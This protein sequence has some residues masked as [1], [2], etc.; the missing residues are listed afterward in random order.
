M[1]RDELL[2]YYERELRFIRKLAGE[3]A[4]KYP[5]VAS[6]L[7]LE[8]TKCE[9]PHVERI[10]EA[11]AM[12][13]GRIH[14]RLDD[15]FSEI[16]DAMMGIL[17]PHYLRPVPSMTIVQMTA[18]PDV[19][20]VSGGFKIEAGSMLHSAPAGGVRCQFRTSYPLSLY[21]IRVSEVEVM[22]T[23]SLR[24]APIPADARSMLRIRLETQAGV[25]FSALDMDAL[26]F[27]LDATSGEIDALYELFL[28][29]PKGLYVQPVATGEA[30]SP[31]PSG[32]F[33]R[34]EKIQPV[35]FGTDEGL[36]AYPSESFLGYRLLQEYFTFPDKF[37]F[38]ELGGLADV[39]RSADTTILDIMVLLP[40]TQGQIELRVEPANLKLG[41]TP[42]VNLFPR[43]TDPIR[44]TQNT[45]EYPI[46][47]DVRALDA[48]EVHSI[49]KVTSITPG[50]GQTTEY[51]P[52]YGVR[53][54][55]NGRETA[56]WHAQRRP[57]M[58]KGDSGS[59]VF[60]S[61]VD[62]QFKLLSAPVDVLH[63]DALCTNRAL[64]ARLPFGNAA[65]DF[66][67]EGRP[68]IT[69]IVALRKPTDPLPA[70]AASSNRWRLISHLSLNYI[71]LLD[72]GQSMGHEGD[73]KALNALQEI[74]RLYDFADSPV[75]RQKV[76]GVVGLKSRRIVRRVGSGPASGFARGLEAELEFDASQYT[77]SGVF[78]FASV[79]ERF[80]GLYTSVNSFTQTVAK[81]RQHPGVLKRW[82][83]RAGEMTLL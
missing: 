33:V 43:G 23:T 4:E 51:E 71:S 19:S 68:G 66:R 60:I 75:T 16:T 67:L 83:P 49:Q 24:G 74:L 11:F 53:H 20:A 1:R 35:G 50:T 17:Y 29:D 79:L 80:L 22:S 15:E 5:Q 55:S 77:G 65:G 10:I 64:P 59:E 38:V 40:Q 37:L 39:T 18:D 57:S 2:V 28:R 42:A 41:C 45:V 31:A 21:P 47:P 12:L 7:Q 62:P 30:G 9:D 14:L 76:A 25:P 70:P 6:R 3:F 26:T 52:F 34:P 46:E 44:L 36:L 56:Y 81:V 69:K 73:G 13:T 27:F 58:R 72:S 82:S 48:Y 8:A 54:G 61:L 32:R 78:L 63:I